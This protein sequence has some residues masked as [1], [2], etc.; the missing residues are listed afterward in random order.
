MKRPAFQFYPSDWLRDTALRSCSAGARGLWMDMICYMHEGTPY[1]HLKVNQKVILADNLARMCGLTL[2]ETEGYL[3]ELSDA[4]VFETDA[5]GCI[6]SRRMVR[7]EEVRNARAAGGILGGNP[8]LTSGKVNHKVGGK[9]KQKPT[10]SSSSSS[11]SSLGINHPERIFWRL[12][13]VTAAG[14]LASISQDICKLYFDSREAIGWVDR[15]GNP[16]RSMPHDLSKFAS[17]YNETKRRKHHANGTSNR[18]RV[19]K[20]RGV[21]NP[22]GY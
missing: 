6:Y 20:Y 21:G 19:E 15:N 8:A 1:G 13:E 7:D 16:I 4:G 10:P 22:A 17:H 11:S 12:E 9:D 3:A 18:S 14:A 2:Q 5:A